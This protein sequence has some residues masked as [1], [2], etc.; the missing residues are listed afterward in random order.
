MSIRVHVVHQL[1]LDTLARVLMAG[2]PHRASTRAVRRA[3]TAILADVGVDWALRLYRRIRAA[4]VADGTLDEHL[5]RLGE[6]R[7]QIAAA[8]MPALPRPRPPRR[9]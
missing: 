9:S 7:G 6:Y 5:R 3:V 2:P 8:Y 1:D 4:A